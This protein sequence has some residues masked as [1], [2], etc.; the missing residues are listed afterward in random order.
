MFEIRR[1][2]NDFC[3]IYPFTQLSSLCYCGIRLWRHG[4]NWDYDVIISLDNGSE[5]CKLAIGSEVYAR[6]IRLYSRVW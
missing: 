3:T 6:N 1:S 5:D 2:R 4:V